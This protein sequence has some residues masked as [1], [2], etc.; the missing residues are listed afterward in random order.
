M[1]VMIMNQLL[2]IVS[3]NTPYRNILLVLKV[4]VTLP[5]DAQNDHG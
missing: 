1:V 4:M 3:R 5:K 2:V